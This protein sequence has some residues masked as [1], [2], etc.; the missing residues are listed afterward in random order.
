MV[1]KCFEYAVAL[2]G[3]IATGKSTVIAL[4]MQS[5]FRIIDADKIAHEILDEKSAVIATR[6]GEAF[7]V[8]GKVDRKALGAL[9]F[10]DQEKRKIL[11]SFLHP[12]IYARIKDESAKLD[13]RAEPYIVDIP[14]YYEGGRYAIDKVIVVYAKREQQLARLMERDHYSKEEALSRIEA[15]LD[16][17]EKRINASYVIDNSGNLN[18]LAFETQKIKDEII[19]EYRV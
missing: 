7:I 16:I 3:G 14:L 12:L 10:A 9:V 11:E 4:L 5:G 13:K 8:N 19:G 6:F 2:T 1:M 15:Q 17:E 18:Q